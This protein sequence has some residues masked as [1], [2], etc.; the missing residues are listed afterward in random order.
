MT[1][2]SGDSDV[3]RQT[4]T[5]PEAGARLGLSKNAAYEAAKRGELPTLK[6]GG[7]LFVPIA[8]FDK[9]LA[10]VEAKAAA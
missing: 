7:R 10:S 3:Q 6:I 5:V 9:M 1:I 8:A 2:K 4:Y